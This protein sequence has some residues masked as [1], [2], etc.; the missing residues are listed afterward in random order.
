MGLYLH[1]C[2]ALYCTTYAQYVCPYCTCKDTYVS[3]AVHVY[4]HTYHF[5]GAQHVPTSELVCCLSVY[6]CATYVRM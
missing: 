6:T 3:R 2:A 4:I 5:T 1:L